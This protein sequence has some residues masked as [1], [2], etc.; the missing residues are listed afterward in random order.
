MSSTSGGI[1]IRKCKVSYH[2]YTVY[3][4]V[5]RTKETQTEDI[6]TFGS[7]A[8]THTLAALG[9]IEEDERIMVVSPVPMTKQARRDCAIAELLNSEADYV[10]D[11]KVSSPASASCHRVPLLGG[12]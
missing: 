11:L 9:V 2:W 10:S 4:A 5:L 6:L 8:H 12:W 1:A 7:R 3:T